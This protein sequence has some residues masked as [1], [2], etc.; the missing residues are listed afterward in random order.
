M[1]VAFEIADR[2]LARRVVAERDVDVGVDQAGNRRHAAGIDHHIGGLDR[3]AD[4]V[5][6]DDD[7]AAVG[8][9]RVARDERIAPVARNDL[10]R[11]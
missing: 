9:D 6:T 1:Q 8:D 7:A 3:R 2:A 10:R 11:D 4:A 5:P